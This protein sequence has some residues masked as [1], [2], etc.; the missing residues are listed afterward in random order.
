MKKLSLITICYNA[1]N[2]I[3]RTIKSILNQKN[4]QVE[5]LLIDGASTDNTVAIAKKYESE[6]DIFISEKDK[7]IADAFNKGI[8]RA[9]GEFIGLIN[10]DDWLEN[11]SINQLLES[12][13]NKKE[14]DVFYGNLNSWRNGKVEFTAKANHRLLTKEMTLNHP[15]TFVRKTV[16]TQIGAFNTS[17]RCAMDYEFLLRTF[18]RGYRFFHLDQTLVNMSME[19]F[20]DKYWFIGCQE[21]RKAKLENGRSAFK[22]N[23]WFVRQV[24]AILLVKSSLTLGL[25]SVLKIYRK[26]FA[27]VEKY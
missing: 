18:T 24:I 19:G 5:Y 1:E 10:A 25:G 2:T 13:S 26:H 17:Y 20:S 27:K 6:I 23:A 15:A 12:I 14:I 4:E 9:Q 3:E 21:V 16:Y 8:L 22:A 7:G 11:G